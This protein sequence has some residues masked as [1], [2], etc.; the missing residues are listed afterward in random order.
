VPVFEVFFVSARWGLAMRARGSRMGGKRTG[1]WGHGNGGKGNMLY[2][3][4]KRWP[5]LGCVVM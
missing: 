2:S 1:S 4:R 3:A 5:G